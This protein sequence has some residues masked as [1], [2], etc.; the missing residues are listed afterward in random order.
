MIMISKVNGHKM[1]NTEEISSCNSFRKSFKLMELALLLIFKRICSFTSKIKLLRF[2]HKVS[3]W[4]VLVL[5]HRMVIAQER[6]SNA[7]SKFNHLHLHQQDWET[8][9]NFHRGHFLNTSI[10]KYHKLVKRPMEAT[11]DHLINDS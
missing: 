5:Y 9:E 4:L 10:N 11:C 3:R 8:M 7:L 1:T 2:I 6:T